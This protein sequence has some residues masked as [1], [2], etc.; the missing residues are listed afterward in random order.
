MTSPT[1]GLGLQGH[2]WKTLVSD[3]YSLWNAK[4]CPLPQP[5]RCLQEGPKPSKILVPELSASL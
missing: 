2:L 4:V 3:A 1:L 5:R